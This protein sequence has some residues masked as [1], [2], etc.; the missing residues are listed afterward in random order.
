MRKA[1]LQRTLRIANRIPLPILDKL[2]CLTDVLIG[3]SSHT[4]HQR[5]LPSWAWSAPGREMNW[6]YNF[7]NATF[8][9]RVLDAE[10]AVSGHDPMRW[11][12]SGRF[13]LSGEVNAYIGNTV[14]LGAAATWW[15][16]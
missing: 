3:P 15:Y 16:L 14:R 4:Y 1:T 13:V 6:Y 7:K 2:T 11:V 8:R 12:S 10:V 9:A 5:L